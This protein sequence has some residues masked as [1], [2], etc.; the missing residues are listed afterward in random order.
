MSLLSFRTDFSTNCPARRHK[1]HLAAK[2]P[3]SNR[4]VP[5]KIVPMFTGL[6]H[7]RHSSVLGNLAED[8]V[9]E[10]VAAC[11]RVRFLGGQA[12]CRQGEP[13]E[14]MFVILT[15]RVRI[16]VESG[17]NRRRTLNYLG[18]GD[19]F[20]EM[21][22]LVGS[23]R[24]ANVIAVTN[25]ELLEL[26]RAD[27]ERT[28]AQIPRFATNLSRSLGTWLNGQ[29]SGRRRP[30]EKMYAA[31]VRACSAAVP[32]AAQLARTLVAQGCRVTLLSDQGQPPPAR[33]WQ[34]MPT[35]RS[36]FERRIL[37]RLDEAVRNKDRVLV[38]IH[39]A[40]ATPSLLMQQEQ[41]W[42]IVDAAAG[43]DENT[44]DQID[45]LL[46]RAPQLASRMRLVWTIAAGERLP[47]VQPI[48]LAI[49]PPLRMVYAERQGKVRFRAHDLSRLAHA[50]R[51]IQFGLAL[52][53]GGA[54]GMAHLGVL[55]VCQREGI[56]FDRV[57]G[58]SAGAIIA[59]GH[60]AGIPLADI[61]TFFEREMT[62]PA[63]L[64]RLPRARQWY[65]LAAFRWRWLEA[66]L[67][68]YLHD[69]A[70]ED[71][72]LP[73]QTVSVDLVSGEP[74]IRS[75]GDVVGA[76]L[77][78][79]NHPIFGAPIL[80]DGEALVDGGV[81]MNVPVTALAE[82]GVDV[83]VAVDVGKKLATAFAGNSPDT[84]TA[85]MRR[86][87]YLATLLRVTD[88]EQKNLATLHGAHCDAL[89]APDTAPFPF[90]DFSQAEGLIEAGRQAAELALPTIKQLLAERFDGQPRE[91]DTAT[92][93][94]APA[95]RRAA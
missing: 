21:S 26:A 83:T 30:P 51:G 91:I 86:P 47:T 2:N 29:I 24:S 73:T 66:K 87:G 33:T 93:S 50:M 64:R 28:L 27:F 9:R 54:R 5:A 75:T 76:V 80:R 48:P 56:Y 58:T 88:I 45:V 32:L 89:I 46:Q 71:L 3:S 35:R 70:L 16:D 37:Q 61:R 95:R 79:I 14:S 62:P 90:D 20:G 72:I 92:E 57:A 60:A 13:G 49:Q 19:H 78:S 44:I 38:D 31:L 41:V 15:G 10:I 12:I 22:M 77:E 40:N 36:P 85:K 1:D 82:Q 52:G 18:P 8:E 67:R 59:A 7:I 94:N 6:E 23:P 43:V 69:S 11:R 4:L 53:G 34:S 42:W 81:L 68:R 25:T 17:P 74:R 84:P 55:E 39:P 65:L 63:W